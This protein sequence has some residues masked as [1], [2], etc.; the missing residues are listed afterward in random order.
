MFVWGLVSR[1]GRVCIICM[2]MFCSVSVMLGSIPSVTFCG[3]SEFLLNLSKAIRATT[4]SSKCTRANLA[5][6]ITIPGRIYYMLHIHDSERTQGGSTGHHHNPIWW[7]LGGMCKTI[8]P[9]ACMKY[10]DVHTRQ[11]TAG[12]NSARLP[13]LAA[14]QQKAG[15]AM[16]VEDSYHALTYASLRQRDGGAL[17]YP[18][19]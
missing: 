1:Y 11:C 18:S 13:S 3:V 16:V 2:Y 17:F 7:I 19:C 14:L 12:E 10:A 15:D 4:L 9:T 8:I 6:A 5:L